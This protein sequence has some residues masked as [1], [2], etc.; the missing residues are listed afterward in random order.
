MIM[1]IYENQKVVVKF[2]P[3]VPCV[4]WTP[5]QFMNGE[6]W[7]TPFVKGMDFITE[8]IK[9]QPN[10]SW[11]NDAR[12]LKTVGID[13]L[14]WLNKNVNDR[15]L[16]MGVRKVGFVLPENIFGKM[17]VKFYV[18]FTNKRTDNQ[19]HIKAFTSYQEAVNWL[20]GK[21]NIK[22]DEVKL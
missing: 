17:A 3:T 10:I 21:V 5:L 9:T 22:I 2:D 11:L 14:K 6:E 19:F 18:E 15:G 1:I 12:K 16:K 8:K 7:S 4:I 13:D 20:S